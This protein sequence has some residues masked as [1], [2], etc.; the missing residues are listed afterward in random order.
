MF[1]RPLVPGFL[2]KFD[3]YLLIN[4]PV[5][6]SARTHL[7]V[8]Y[9]LLFA[10]VLSFFCFIVP[11]DAREQSDAGSWVLFVIV[12]VILGFVGWLIY[13][14]RFNVFKRFGQLPPGYG[15]TTFFLYMLSILAIVICVYIPLWVETIR[16]N[17]TYS[18]E[19]II[20]D[21]NTVNLDLCRLERD[22]MVLNWSRDTAIFR[23][24]MPPPEAEEEENVAPVVSDTDTVAAV[25]DA[26]EASSRITYYTYRDSADLF[27]RIRIEDSLV[28]PNDSTYV[29]FKCP[30]YIF[31][32]DQLSDEYSRE[33]RLR[34]VDIFNRVL[35]NYHTPDRRAVRRELD[36]LFMKYKTK[37]SV[38]SYTYPKKYHF[39]RAEYMSHIQDKYNTYVFSRSMVNISEKKYRWKEYIM[40]ELVYP[41]YYIVLVVSLLVFIFRHSTIRTFFLSI[42]TAVILLILTSLG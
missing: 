9:A 40:R 31:I 29:F 13:L 1:K 25:T 28:R 34:N 41:L 27:T 15:L 32:T 5:I 21:A 35:K 36:S 24:Y 10:A 18:N 17:H 16:A 23:K 39:I 26:P 22:S 2:K 20:R 33:K 4:K 14:L 7:V 37:D 19:E 30:D 12:I 38:E 3:E 11:F 8:W 6:W 42:L